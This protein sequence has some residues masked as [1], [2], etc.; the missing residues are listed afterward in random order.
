[1]RHSIADLN[2]LS[3]EDFVRVVGPVFEHSPWIAAATAAQR[4]FATVGDLHRAMCER[5]RAAPAGLQLAL[6]R[7][8]PDLASRAELTEESSH[9]QASVGLNRLAPEEAAVFQEKLAAYRDRFEFPFVVCARLNRKETIMAA[10]VRRL[11]N[12]SKQERINALEEIFKIAD[13]RLRDLAA[14]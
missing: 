2:R 14:A 12:S 1:M 3:R 4:P 13:L 8:H 10:L 7:A 11:E 9:E 5:V 6:I